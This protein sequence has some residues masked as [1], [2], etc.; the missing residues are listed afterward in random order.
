LVAATKK[1]EPYKEGQYVTPSTRLAELGL[2]L[3]DVATPV[4]SYVPAIVTG[5]IVLTSG[6]IPLAGGKFV[7]QGIV[8]ENVTLEQAQKAAEVCALNAI[9]AAGSAIGGMDRIEQIVRVCVFVASSPKF[10]DQPKVANAASDLFAKIFGDAGKHVRSAVGV[11]SLP[12]NVPVELELTAR[13][14]K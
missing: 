1:G 13:V 11:A 5:D 3:P 4:G 8:G 10:T 6:Q 12:L 2:S 7:C 14:R 9:A